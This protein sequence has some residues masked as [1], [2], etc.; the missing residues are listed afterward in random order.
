MRMTSGV[1]ISCAYAVLEVALGGDIFDF[2]ATGPLPVG[3]ARL[4]F[5]RIMEGISYLHSNGIF[6]KDIKPEKILLDSHLQ[7]KI[8]GFRYSLNI[9]QMNGALATIKSGTQGYMA[10]EIVAN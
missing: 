5:K 7:P 3:I 10:P 4:Y 6:H 2:V 9:S 8:S 1:I